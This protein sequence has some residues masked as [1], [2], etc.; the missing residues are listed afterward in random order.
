MLQA[1]SAS[2][3]CIHPGLNAASSFP[4]ALDYFSTASTCFTGSALCTSGSMA[5]PYW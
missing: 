1:S 3:G 5:L 4:E 2:P